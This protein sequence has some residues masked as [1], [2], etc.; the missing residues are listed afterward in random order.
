MIKEFKP[1][2]NEYF[3]S[4]IDEIIDSIKLYPYNNHTVRLT[5]CFKGYGRRL[6]V[7][8]SFKKYCKEIYGLDTDE[9][10]MVWKHIYEKY[11][12]MVFKKEMVNNGRYPICS[13]LDYTNEFMG[14]GWEEE[15]KGWCVKKDK[16]FEEMKIRY[17]V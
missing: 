8:D 10:F 7:V 17:K 13:M 2:P 3:S 9:S 11:N 4:I 16:R 15:Y 6:F 1:L 12:R 5:A 14:K